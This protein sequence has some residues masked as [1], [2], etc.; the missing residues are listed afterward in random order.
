MNKTIIT[1]LSKMS[2]FILIALFL[3]TIASCNNGAK[4]VDTAVSTNDLIAEA[5]KLDSLFLV[6]FNNG[7]ADAIMKLHWNSPELCTY[8]PGEMQVNG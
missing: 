5:N 8:P 7:D 4:K 1:K 2:N 3:F 6:A